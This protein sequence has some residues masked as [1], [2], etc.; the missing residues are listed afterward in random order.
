MGNVNKFNFKRSRLDRIAGVGDHN[1]RFIQLPAARQA[2]LNH[3]GRQLR[4]IGRNV[5]DNLKQVDQR[6]NMVLMRVRHE[7][8]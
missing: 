2:R 3:A 4:R 7:N 8:A 5:L 1:L 6:A